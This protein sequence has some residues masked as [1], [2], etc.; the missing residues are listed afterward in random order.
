MAVTAIVGVAAGLGIAVSAR[1]SQ[2]IDDAQNQFSVL[3]FIQRERNAHV[4]R[5][6]ET[7]IL[8]L[9]TATDGGPCGAGG[10]ELVA[11]RVTLP[12]VFPPPPA[13]ELARESI[14]ASAS[15][16]PGPAL[17]VDAYARSVNAAGDPF[18]QLLTVQQR[19]STVTILFRQDGSVVPSFDAP[20]AIVVAP[21]I[22]DVGTRTTP[23][24]T[25][26]AVPNR[27]PRAR[28]VFLE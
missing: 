7:E 20:A 27:L 19:T 22:A 14:N 8:V 9:C 26:Q 15:F 10:N 5:G 6:M 16:A 23:N 11:Y 28:Q 21:K 1:T 3:D 2:G 12:V 25:P 4:N 13:R 18:N 17:F 24:P